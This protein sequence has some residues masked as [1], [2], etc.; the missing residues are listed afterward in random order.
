MPVFTLSTRPLRTVNVMRFPLLSDYVRA[1]VA[2]IISGFIA[3]NAFT[4]DVSRLLMVS[5]ERST[6]A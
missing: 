6:A 1:A 2:D 3:P 4:M 5:D